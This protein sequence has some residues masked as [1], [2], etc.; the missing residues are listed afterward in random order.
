ML[1]SL[2]WLRE[3]LPSLSASGS[4]VAR[5]LTHAGLEVEAVVEVGQGLEVVVVAEVRKIEAH[6]TK[7]GLRLVTVDRGSG[8]QR[9]VC[10]ASNVPEPGGRVLLAPLGA[11][12]PGI[13]ALTAR[14]IGGVESQGMLVSEEELGLADSSDGILI[15]ATDQGA[16]GTPLFEVLPE[17]RD[18]IFHIGVTPNRPDALGHVGVARDV[19]A[20]FGLDF[21]S[22][23]AP[24]PRREA[25]ESV[26]KLVSVEIEDLERCPH[27]GAGVVLDVRIAPSPAWL[28]WRLHKLGVRPINNVV[29]IT[30]LILLGYGQPMHAFDLERVRGS[31]IV[32]RRARSGEPFTT[33]DGVARSLDADDLVICDAE[34]PSALAGVMGGQ[35]SE[36]QS[37]TRQVLLEC[38]YFAPRGIRRTARRHG[39]FTESSFRFERGVDWGGVPRVLEIAKGLLTELAEGAAVPGAIHVK[40][41]DPE[42]PRITFRKQRM[43]ALLGTSVDMA[44]A[45]GILRRLGLAVESETSDQASVRGAS[46][47]PDIGREADLI[48][49]VARVRGLDAIP[50]V[51]P[52]IAPQPTRTSGKLE[53][54]AARVAVELGLSEALTYAF[55]SERQ[56]AALRAPA[57]VVHIRNP[58]TE[59]RS[60][61]RTSLLPGLCEALGRA[62]RHGEQSVRL[63]AI[64]SVFLGPGHETESAARPRV[65]ADADALP[66][67]RPTFAAILAGP[68]PSHLAVPSAMDVFDAKGIAVEMVERL[69]GRNARVEHV[70][71][72]EGTRHLHPRGAGAIF[73]G[74][75]RVGVFGP[76]HP[77]VIDALDLGGE[78]FVVELD[79]ASIEALGAHVPRY[80]PIPRLPPVT[81]DVALVVSD[82]VSAAQVEA[83]IREAAGELCESVEL[84]DLF[85][86]DS[87]PEG[88]R[89]LAFHLIYRDPKAAS[90]PEK[91]RTLTDREVDQRHAEVVKAATSRLGGQLRA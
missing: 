49:E 51:L 70:A 27:Y 23:S 89:S 29:D 72:A 41:P 10:G 42:L 87:L 86:G 57:P 36:I 47:R 25:K 38:A 28:R 8:E 75:Q 1:V 69:T 11:V 37:N 33:L 9:V 91:A 60:V 90:D 40:A 65:A 19:A 20:L 74:E 26:E 7:S 88:H 56:L 64:G 63:F 54:S 52:A 82:D 32:V 34:H 16:P 61:M 81:R 6:P 18:T 59:E 67:E 31:K 79:L 13:G 71:N 80:R 45:T 58:L 85:R 30:N 76:L 77:E 39:L 50:T 53:R 83:V 73:A 12:I 5:R 22:P 35:H 48:E 78:A 4:E 43:D 17:A 2:R 84:F 14:S 21:A 24:T 46:W 3:L 62:R 55:V 66:S 68:R 15:L 44:E